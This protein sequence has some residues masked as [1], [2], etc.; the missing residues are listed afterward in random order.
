MTGS[1]NQ[2]C[3]VPNYGRLPVKFV[4]GQGAI[5]TDNIGKEYLDAVSGIAVCGLGHAHPELAE[6]LSKQAGKLWHTS[7]LYRIDLQEQLAGRLTTLA[8]LDKAFFCNSGAEANEAAIKIAR[9]FGTDQGV[10]NPV[11]V[12]MNGSFHGRTMGTLSATGNEKVQA[13]FEPLLS[14][15]EYVSF[16]SLSAVK[17]A[18]ENEHVVAVLVEP[19]QGEGGVILPKSGYLLALR[20]LCDDVGK[21][22]ILDEVQTG[23]GRTGSWFAYQNEK[24]L[25][26]VLTVAKALGNGIPIGACLTR[27]PA[28]DVLQPGTHGSTFG[29]NPLVSSVALKV[30]E[31]LERDG[32][33]EKAKHF[34]KTIL[35][36]FQSQLGGLEGVNE[37]RGRGMMIG[38]ELDRPCGQIV[39]MALETGL[40]V[41]VANDAVIRLLPPLVLKELEAQMLVEKLSDV[42]REFL[43]CPS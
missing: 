34:G 11:I 10:K 16:D 40:L 24:I 2:E 33:I 25:P 6:E 18:L 41:N 22:L 15:F 9:K 23:M 26:D 7:N 36:G 29:G 12:S 37:I 30:I 1:A 42:I 32:L 8:G 38:I 20:E 27:G 17:K 35:E 3:L 5:L 4:S 13:G 14:G 39:S 21:L 31:I 28:S 19:I 43:S